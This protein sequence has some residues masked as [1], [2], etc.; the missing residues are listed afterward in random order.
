MTFF[1]LGAIISRMKK[2]KKFLKLN[3]NSIFDITL[4]KGYKL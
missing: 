4:K 1:F 2:I 3:L